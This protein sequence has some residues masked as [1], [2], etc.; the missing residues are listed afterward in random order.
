MQTLADIKVIL[1]SAGLSPR[2]VLGQNFLIDKNLVTRFLDAAEPL[3]DQLVLEVG[4]GTGT[5]TEGLL[6]RGATVVA[7]ELDRGLAEVLRRRMPTVPGGDRFTLVEGDCLGPGRT[8]NADVRQ[9]LAGRPFRL[10]ANL[11]YAAATPLMLTLLMDHP[12]C[13]EQFVTIQDEVAD[14]LAAKPGDEAYGALSIV[15]QAVATVERLA[16]LPPECFWPRPQVHSAMVRLK[17]RPVPLTGD[18][19]GLLELCQRLFAARRKQIGGTLGKSFPLPTGVD[20]AQR[21]EA[22]TVEQ[23]VEIHRILAAAGSAAAGG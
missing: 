19:R 3:A 21:P 22:L 12:G 10:I 8:L 5:L 23:V 7:C 13:S 18:A 20:K 16:T 1:E 11:P 15:A 4:P 9:T 14:R 17:R 2:K 6:E